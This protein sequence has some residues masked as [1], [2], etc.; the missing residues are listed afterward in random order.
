M[1]FM[2]VAQLIDLGIYVLLS[3]SH[4]LCTEILAQDLINL[5]VFLSVSHSGFF[6]G[7]HHLH[8]FSQHLELPVPLAPSLITTLFF[9][10]ID[11]NVKFPWLCHATCFQNT[12]HSPSLSPPLPTPRIRI[13]LCLLPEESIQNKRL[14]SLQQ[15]TH[16]LKISTEMKKRG[17]FIL[18]IP[19]NATMHCSVRCQY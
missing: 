2:S 15:C 4:H 10:S 7:R 17:L 19:I 6:R 14:T 18:Q 13:R 8:S 11:I 12:I 1:T 16:W 9:E 3:N 5:P